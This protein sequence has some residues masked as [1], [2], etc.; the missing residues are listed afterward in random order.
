MRS[1]RFVSVVLT[2]FVLAH[3]SN[4]SA[5]SMCGNTPTL[6][7]SQAGR[8]LPQYVIMG[9]RGISMINVRLKADVPSILNR[10]TFTL[11]MQGDIYGSQ[12]SLANFT[13]WS[14]GSQIS[15]SRLLTPTGSRRWKLDFFLPFGIQPMQPDVDLVLKGDVLP[16]SAGSASGSEYQASI[17]SPRDIEIIPV[18]LRPQQGNAPARVVVVLEGDVSH[19]VI[20]YT[21]K[22]TLGSS[23]LGEFERVPA[24]EDFLTTLDFTMHPASFGTLEGVTL[25][26]SGEALEGA[27][28]VDLVD[29]NRIFLRS[30]CSPNA[31]HS[32]TVQF[33][34]D[35]LIRF[36]G[37][38]TWLLK[39]DSRRFSAGMLKV[40]IDHPTNVLMSDL[41]TPDIPLEPGITPF[42]VVTVMYQ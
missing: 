1:A 6:V 29:M 27:F 30:V 7:V 23:M 20:A 40:M 42:N 35:I 41:E 9:D 15:D 21:T 25:R 12:P 14:G 39:V 38:W 2:I 32:C 3:T 19:R 34:S 24:E 8:L 5:D 18:D 33:R 26:F 17:A 31:F 11:T 22:V 28:F 37:T 4:I 36:G 13:L 16:L 10:V